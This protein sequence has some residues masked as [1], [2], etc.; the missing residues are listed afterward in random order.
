MASTL[1][2]TDRITFKTLAETDPEGVKNHLSDYD[3]DILLY[4]SPLDSVNKSVTAVT[5]AD[6]PMGV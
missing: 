1:E 6:K 3:A 4:I 5:Y 2:N